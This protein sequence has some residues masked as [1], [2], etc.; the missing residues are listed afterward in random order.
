MNTELDFI[1]LA[2]LIAE[3][4]SL[5]KET[6]SVEYTNLEVFLAM[7]YIVATVEK[8]DKSTVETPV[9]KADESTFEKADESNKADEPIT[10]QPNSYTKLVQ[11]SNGCTKPQQKSQPLNPNQQVICCRC[12]FCAECTSID[13]GQCCNCVYY[14]VFSPCYILEGILSCLVGCCE[15]CSD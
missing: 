1:R 5:L 2:T 15:A 10:Q 4:E 13:L 3:I 14:T 8:A 12:H 7:D 11:Q 6:K 9:E